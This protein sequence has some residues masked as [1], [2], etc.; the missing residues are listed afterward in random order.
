MDEYDLIRS[1]RSAK[2]YQEGCLVLVVITTVGGLGHS[3]GGTLTPSER[4]VTRSSIA[5]LLA[6]SL[7]F[8]LWWFLGQFIALLLMSALE[9]TQPFC[10]GLLL[11]VNPLLLN[12]QHRRSGR[13]PGP[14]SFGDLVIGEGS[15]IW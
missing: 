1:N 9:G 5:K 7:S 2:A 6:F 14:A 4:S 8:N 3:K 12:R 10:E 13:H 15:R 11:H